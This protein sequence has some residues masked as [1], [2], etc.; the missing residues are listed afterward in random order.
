M[1]TIESCHPCRFVRLVENSI[2]DSV[3]NFVG[4][5]DRMSRLRQWLH[6]H[7]YL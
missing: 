5:D 1:K 6:A 4:L 7:G 2:G 3:D